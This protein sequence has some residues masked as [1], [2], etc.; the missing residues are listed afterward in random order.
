[1]HDQPETTKDDDLKREAFNII[2]S[3]PR[4]T[5]DALQVLA[6][7]KQFMELH[8]RPADKIAANDHSVVGFPEESSPMRSAAAAIA[9]RTK[10]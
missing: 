7:A 2:A 5:D 4:D 1:M 10:P 3:L 9:R 8:F 6:Y